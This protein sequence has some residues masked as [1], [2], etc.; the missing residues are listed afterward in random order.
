LDENAVTPAPAKTLLEDHSKVPEIL[1]DPFKGIL[2]V[3]DRTG[4]LK[5]VWDSR[6][7]DEVDEVRAT[8]DRMRAKGY[9]AYTVDKKDGSK[10]EIIREFDPSLEKIILSPPLAGG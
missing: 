6:N 3:M 1:A 7:E 2:A 9:L 4:D 10:G 8:F 5:Y